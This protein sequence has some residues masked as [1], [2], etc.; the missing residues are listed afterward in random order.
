MATFRM[1][2]RLY[3]LQE[4][5]I[6]KDEHYL[7]CCVSF[8]ENIILVSNQGG[9]G[10]NGLCI[11]GLINNAITNRNS[12]ILQCELRRNCRSS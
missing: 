10:M 9:T 4:C 6:V 7:L 11:C 2:H 3:R 8:P 12:I 5:S 1:F